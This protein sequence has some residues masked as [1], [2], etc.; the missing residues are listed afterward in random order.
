M[1]ILEGK[2][3]TKEAVDAEGNTRVMNTKKTMPDTVEGCVDQFGEE[4]VL[5]LI[6]GEAGVRIG[7]LARELLREEKSDEEIQEAVEAFDFAPQGRTS[8]TE[9]ARLRQMEADIKKVQGKQMTFE[10]FQ[11]KYPSEDE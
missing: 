10:D 4:T 1:A 3:S 7:T 11:E 8:T 6:N 9:V 5:V 2:Y